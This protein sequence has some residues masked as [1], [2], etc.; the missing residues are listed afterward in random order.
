ML[1]LRVIK[2]KYIKMRDLGEVTSQSNSQKI[3]VLYRMESKEP[4]QK[5]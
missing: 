3:T 2:L 4:F 5:F 1:L